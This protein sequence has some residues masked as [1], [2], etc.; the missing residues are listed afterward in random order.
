MNEQRIIKQFAELLH[1]EFGIQWIVNPKL[2]KNYL[3]MFRVLNS[4]GDK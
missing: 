3:A 2:Y 4:T 1:M